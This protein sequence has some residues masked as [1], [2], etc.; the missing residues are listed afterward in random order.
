MVYGT[1]FDENLHQVAKERLDF[2]WAQGIRGADF[3][4]SAIGPALSVFGRFERVI[5]LSGVAVTVG[6]FLDEVRSIVTN[7]ALTKILKTAH[8]ATIDAETRFYVVWKWSYGG[9]KVPA[10]EAFKW[11]KPSVE[12]QRD[13]GP[14]WRP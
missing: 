8:T 7:Y 1:T 6:Q 9:E 14:N 10:D 5:K 3:L 4:I 11:P 13:V 12:Y 2:F